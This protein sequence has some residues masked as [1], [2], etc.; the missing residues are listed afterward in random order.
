MTGGGEFAYFTSDGGSNYNF[1]MWCVCACARG[2]AP[3]DAPRRLTGRRCWH[4]APDRGRRYKNPVLVL[5][6]EVNF[7]LRLGANTGGGTGGMEGVVFHVQSDNLDVSGLQ[8]GGLNYHL[9]I[10]HDFAVELDCY[11]SI[12][13]PNDY[14]SSTRTRT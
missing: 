14:D 6:M 4:C 12:N 7:T 2:R 1:A 5:G 10:S 9:G 8:T 11:R 13:T 3:R